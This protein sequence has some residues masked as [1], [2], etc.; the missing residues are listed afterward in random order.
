MS[1]SAAL[2]DFM[3]RLTTSKLKGLKQQHD[4]FEENK[5]ATLNVVRSEPDLSKQVRGLFDALVV[6]DVPD[7]AP[8]KLRHFLELED[9]CDPAPTAK[10]QEWKAD[11][12]RRFGFLSPKYEHAS[13]FG[14]V[15]TEWLKE[16]RNTPALQR[17]SPS[18][19]ADDSSQ[20]SFERVDHQKVYDQWREWE[21]LV[22]DTTK[23]SDADAIKAYLSSLFKSA[24]KSTKSRKS[25]LKSLRTQVE[26][27]DLGKIDKDIL[28]WSI[29]DLLRGDLLVPSKRAALIDI[30]D[31]DLV[32]GEM[33]DVLNIQINNLDQWSWGN[34]PVSIELRRQVNGKYRFYMDEELLQALLLHFIGSKW[35]VHLKKAFL[36]FFYSRAWQLSSYRALDTEAH[37]RR[38]AFLGSFNVSGSCCTIHGQRLEDYELE[39]FMT[40][41]K[42]A[43]GKDEIYYEDDTTT[44]NEDLSDAVCPMKTKQSLLHLVTTES[45]INTSL[46]GSFTVLKSGFRRFGPSLSHTTIFA[47]LEFFGVRDRWLNFFRKFLATPLR[48]VH[49]GPE[50]TANIRRCGVPTNY[51]LG[52]ALGEIVLFCLDFAV[53]QATQN[54]LYRVHNDLWFWGQEDVC[55][56]AWETIGEF[57]KTMGLSIN[58][59]KTGAVQVTEG[60]ST[61]EVSKS[62]PKGKVQWGFL[63]MDPSGEWVI[64][65]Q[66]VDQQVEELRRLLKASRSV[67]ATVQVWNV[68]VSR[69]LADNLG[70]PQRCLGQRHLDMVIT[71]FN[72]IQ[73]RL[74]SDAFGS[75][76]LIEYLKRTIEERFHV[77]DLP[78]GFFY[79]PVELGGLD[80][81]DPLVYLLFVRDFERPQALKEQAIGEV[82][83][84]KDPR[85]WIQEAFE[86]EEKE[87]TDCKKRYHK[88][89]VGSM[90]RDGYMP[91]SNKPF[92]SLEE[93]TRYREDASFELWKAYEQLRKEPDEKEIILTSDVQAAL[94]ELPT[95]SKT[96]SGIHASELTMSS[97]YKRVAQLYAGGV[98]E[99][100][101][102][103]SMG[104]EK[105]LPIGMVRMLRNKMLLPIGMVRRL[106]N[107]KARW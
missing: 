66:E 101:G 33:V 16:P 85:K 39:F 56:K 35:A 23:K 25:P 68:Y 62:L 46:Y 91:K 80:V 22:F 20:D 43:I 99:R 11:L 54:N 12:E 40:Q 15:V 6:H 59:E 32:L 8:K 86:L 81:Y 63:M 103:L 58:E 42:P 4:A 52:N 24:T 100:F 83:K 55:V 17:K 88:G 5:R 61:P 48:F 57:A 60:V 102:S 71:N 10:L 73:Q 2:F 49:N 84:P 94:Q 45:L 36:E 90:S 78:D 79:F 29:K 38:E 74:F 69:F 26:E 70:R 82:K 1:S 96:H 14:Q 41:L 92:M 19:S 9:I 64:N 21:T 75:S 30:K 34:E 95:A 13:L 67:F 97:Y 89:K 105:L 65:D 53:N 76:S 31:N 27:F 44:D 107:E 47:V 51:T 7:V 28:K 104:Q 106:R 98:L 93:F 72:K 3:Q 18:D 50:S 87:Y 77:K 37:A